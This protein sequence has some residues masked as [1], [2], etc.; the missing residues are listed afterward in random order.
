M[1]LVI[2]QNKVPTWSQWLTAF[3]QFLEI[4]FYF[5][6]QSFTFLNLRLDMVRHIHKTLFFTKRNLGYATQVLLSFRKKK[7][8][9]LLWT[10]RKRSQWIYFIQSVYISEK[11]RKGRQLCSILYIFFTFYI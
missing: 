2:L 5:Y 6:P 11:I 3:V 9:T 10:G 7:T 1:K 8:K 4:F